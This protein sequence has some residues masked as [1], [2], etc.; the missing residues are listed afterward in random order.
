MGCLNE[1]LS[2]FLNN[3]W[4]V[5]V[6]AMWIQSCS[7]IGYLFGSISPTIKSSLNYNQRQVARLGVAKDLGDSVG[8]LAGSLSEICRSGLLFSLV[9]FRILLD[10]VGFG[11]SSRAAALFCRCGL[12]VS[13][14]LLSKFSSKFSLLIH[15]LAIGSGPSTCFSGLMLFSLM[16]S[17][18]IDN[19]SV[20]IWFCD[21]DEFDQLSALYFVFS[22]I[23]RIMKFLERICSCIIIAINAGF[24][25]A[26]KTLI[27]IV[28]ERLRLLIQLLYGNSFDIKHCTFL[29][30]WSF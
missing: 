23:V 13:C 17:G 3:R 5:F 1:R 4:L 15:R 24:C 27:F 11:L 19:I 6:A 7:G 21:Y 9:Q 14:F 29:L 18:I 10:M 22:W 30:I 26:K 28:S 16:W 20:F 25:P 12:W 8:F 2:P